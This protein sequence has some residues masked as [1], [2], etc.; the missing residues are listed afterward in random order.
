MRGPDWYRRPELVL[1][2]LLQGAARGDSVTRNY[3]RA[4]VLAVDLEGS[5]LQNE[6]GEG[7]I[8]SVDRDGTVRQFDA[9]VGPNNP[10]GSIKARVLT[11]GLDRLL[12]DADVRIFWP[13]FPQDQ[14]GTPISPGEHVYVVFDGDELNHG[15]WLSRAP[16]HESANSFEGADSYTAPSAQQSAMDF[17]EPNEPEYQR[18]DAHAGLAPPADPNSFFEET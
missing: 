5:R 3:Y 14:I 4:A 7:G 18:T 8:R 2:E 1:A 6:S 10:R 17:F 9:L 11:D 12:D 13:M 16:G 15:L